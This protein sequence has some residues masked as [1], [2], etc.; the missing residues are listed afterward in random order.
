[1]LAVRHSPSARSAPAR[2]SHA[3]AR[4]QASCRRDP[5]SGPPRRAR[6]LRRLA[7]RPAPPPPRYRAGRAPPPPLPP[8]LRY[9]LSLT[10]SS[11]C[12]SAC[13]TRA[14]TVA[15]SVD[16]LA[17]GEG[18]GHG[19]ACGPRSR[20]RHPSGPP[21]WPLCV[22]TAHRPRQA[23]AGA[24]ETVRYRGSCRPVGRRRRDDEGWGATAGG[25]R[26]RSGTDP[27]GR[28]ERG[29]GWLSPAE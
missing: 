18:P 27:K 29:Y 21:A 17:R 26:P 16:R 13:S 10:V 28:Q 12:A 2:Q 8:E 24:C 11:K 3:Q 7:V 4:G 20:G 5:W 22:S 1:M 15:T 25:M 9:A 23:T 14:T 6:R 19:Y